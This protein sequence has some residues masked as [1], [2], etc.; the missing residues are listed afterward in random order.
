MNDQMQLIKK[1]KQYIEQKSL[2]ITNVDF[3]S[4]KFVQELEVERLRILYSC[5]IKFTHVPNNI[6]QL[7][8]ESCKLVNINGIGQMTQLLDLDLSSNSIVEISDIQ[9]LINLKTL[10]FLYNQIE[11]IKPLQ[12][13]MHLTQLSLYQNRIVDIS[14]LKCLKNLDKLNI[15]QN[16]INSIHP[17][18]QLNLSELHISKNQISDISP[19]R[20]LKNCYKLNLSFNQIV[21][22]SVL[23]YLKKLEHLYLS[24]NQIVY[25][26]SI[27]KLTKIKEL[28]LN[29]NNIIDLSPIPEFINKSQRT[30]RIEY[31]QI[32]TDNQTV[33]ANRLQ[34]IYQV[35][36]F[37]YMMNKPRRQMKNEM[38]L[39]KQKIQNQCQILNTNNLK[40]SEKL[41]WMYSQLN[42]VLEMT[43][44]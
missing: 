26:D 28:Q 24:N 2:K 16:Q 31:Q 37:I 14:A 21:D 32:P 23:Q 34:L 38:L 43:N 20:N 36:N 12:N 3:Q 41:V 33:I 11:N 15:G 9:H 7:Q 30:C 1:Y 5:N 29:C 42:Q 4:F 27:S 17:L 10:Q 19:L 25:V 35:Q 39:I 13:L 22:I 8:I 40:F 6:T 44:Q 18:S